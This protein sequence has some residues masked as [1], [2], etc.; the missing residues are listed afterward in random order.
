MTS[1]ER[2]Q[3]AWEGHAA[4][5]LPLTTWCFGLPVPPEVSWRRGEEP[6]RY[7]YSLRMEHL[8]TLPEPWTLED[9]FQR[10]LAWQRLGVDD[11]LEVS[12]PWSVHPGVT[13][14][15]SRVEPRT[16]VREYTTPDGVLRHAVTRTG[17]EQGAGWV[18]QPDH[19]PL[20]EDFNIPRAVEQAVSSPEDVARV[21]WLYAPPDGEACR[22]FAGRME[23]V[24]RFAAGHGVAVQAWSAFGMDAAVWLAGTQSAILM[25]M[26][27]PEALERLMEI[28]TEA[29]LARTE[30]AAAHPGVDLIVQRGWYSSIDFWSPAL[31]ERFVFPH[32]RRVA[33]AAHRHGKKLAYVMTTGVEILGPRLADAGVDVLYFAD[34]LDPVQ[35]NVSLERLRD[36]LGGRMTLVGGISAISL[37]SREPGRVEREV[38]RAV[39]ALGA[40]RRFILHPVDALFP[41]TPW[42]GVQELLR[43]WER[44]R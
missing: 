18:V 28:I 11:L 20:F 5:H 15:D 32:V 30:L 26:D 31:F 16:M 9:D 13:W 39:E 12:V 44:L 22:R 6:V 40:T 17:E 4:D 1:K 24:Q 19:V 2:I 36:L 37:G 7:W 27:Q 29:D 23:R 38:R 42:S 43:A 14:Q 10:V 3:A 8:H 35:K 21:R 41:D 34:P 33:A 25:A